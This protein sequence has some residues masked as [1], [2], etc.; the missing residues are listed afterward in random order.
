[1]LSSAT[2][3]Y[4]LNISVLGVSELLWWG[5]VEPLHLVNWPSH[6]GRNTIKY[7]FC[8]RANQEPE[9]NTSLQLCL[10]TCG[11]APCKMLTSNQNFPSRQRASNKTPLLGENKYL[12]K[13]KRKEKR[14]KGTEVPAE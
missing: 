5:F 4:R 6:L 9:Q 13:K 7:A 10:S 11:L 8:V 2:V 14:R 3:V 12:P 1:M